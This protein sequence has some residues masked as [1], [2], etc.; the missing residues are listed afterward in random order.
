MPKIKI[1]KM[2]ILPFYANSYFLGRYYSIS[3]F[4]TLHFEKLI[5]KWKKIKLSE[6]MNEWRNSYFQHWYFDW[7]CCSVVFFLEWNKLRNPQFNFS[8]QNLCI[9]CNFFKWEGK[10]TKILHLLFHRIWKNIFSVRYDISV[11]YL[12]FSQP[13]SNYHA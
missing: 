2:E 8:S 6:W 11:K 9:K 13:T 1:K 10:E 12:L 4:G 7:K 3:I 5:K